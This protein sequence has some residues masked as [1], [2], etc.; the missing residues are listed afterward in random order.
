MVRWII[1]AGVVFAALGC[2]PE[3]EGRRSLVTGPRVLAVRSMP[4]A[5]RPAEA[6]S[7]DALFVNTDGI[8]DPEPLDW[9]L[10]TARKPLTESGAVSTTCLAR[11]GD[12]LEALGT[13]GAAMA[14]MAMDVCAQF[15]PEP[16]TPEKGEPAPRP[17]DPDTTG[18]Y[19]QPV[20]VVF[21]DDAGHDQYSIGVTR[22]SC[23]LGGATQEQ[24]AEFTM[25]ARPNENPE[26][27][28][29]VRGGDDE[30]G[31]PALDSEDV[32]SVAPGESIQLIARW[33]S[34]PVE[35]ECGDGI[36]SPGED[37]A[38]PSCD[39]DCT[40]PRGC[41]GSEPYIYFDTLTRKLVDRREVM[42]VSWFASDGEFEHDRTGRSE[43][44]ADQSDSENKWT[45]PEAEGDVRLWVVLR[46]DRGG[47]GWGGYKLRVE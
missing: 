39:E 22:L 24:S 20:R 47:V 26:L 6:V 25:K 8:A 13:G 30:Q 32:L 46:D 27:D 23:G 43:A 17:V 31:L 7:Y 9:A 33:P 15:G 38:M 5:A 14:D 41:R 29:V 12:S 11:E 4:A 44:E 42:R 16:K 19:Y 40:Q 35:A 45:A 10:C 28:A 21:A 34:C 37:T 3:L 36:C 1:L 18:G 2:K